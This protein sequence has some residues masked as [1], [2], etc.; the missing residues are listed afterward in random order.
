MEM[1]SILVFDITLLRSTYMLH[2]DSILNRFFSCKMGIQFMKNDRIVNR[3]SNTR[4]YLT[5]ILYMELK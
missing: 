4:D 3:V 2:P 5:L 1:C